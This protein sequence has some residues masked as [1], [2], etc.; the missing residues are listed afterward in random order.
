MTSSPAR[1]ID[2]GTDNT[3]TPDE[4]ATEADTG[5]IKE[6]AIN[7]ANTPKTVADGI[8]N[9]RFVKMLVYPSGD[10]IAAAAMLRSALTTLDTPYHITTVRTPVEA[11]RATSGTEKT[12]TVL[13]I[14]VDLP[15]IDRR[16]P[17]HEDVN[18]DERIDDESGTESETGPPESAS[19]DENEHIDDEDPAPVRDLDD[20]NELAEED[21]TEEGDDGDESTPCTAK[22]G[23]ENGARNEEDDGAE[24]DDERHE[25]AVSGQDEAAIQVGTLPTDRTPR[26]SE[27]EREH[28]ARATKESE[29]SESERYRTASEADSWRETHPAKRGVKMATEAVERSAVGNEPVP[30]EGDGHNEAEIWP[31]NG[32]SWWAALYD[33]Q[34]ELRHRSDKIPPEGTEGTIIASEANSGDERTTSVQE[35]SAIAGYEAGE[36]ETT[37][38]DEGEVGR[39]E[40]NEAKEVNEDDEIGTAQFITDGGAETAPS[41]AAGCLLSVGTQLDE[42]DRNENTEG[43]SLGNV[44]TGVSASTHIASTIASM[45]ERHDE[46]SECEPVLFLA[47][48]MIYSS[49]RNGQFDLGKRRTWPTQYGASTNCERAQAETIISQDGLGT[50]LQSTPSAVQHT[51]FVHADFSGDMNGLAEFMRSCP[52]IDALPDDDEEDEWRQFSEMIRRKSG[53]SSLLDLLIGCHY[54]PEDRYTLPTV[55]GYADV[56]HTLACSGHTAQ[57]LEFASRIGCKTDEDN[58]K[59]VIDRWQNCS[60]EIHDHVRDAEMVTQLDGEGGGAVYEL[61]NTDGDDSC[62]SVPLGQIAVLIDQYRNDEGPTIIMGEENAAAADLSTHEEVRNGEGVRQILAETVTCEA[63]TIGCDGGIAYCNTTK[64]AS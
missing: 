13:S 37:D 25:D 42:R 21:E 46:L 1:P 49:G 14:G 18:G 22:N 59:M 61:E 11:A 19:E 15:Q 54:L 20:D 55:E 60:D 33:V 39:T 28:E 43:N 29:E 48:M 57:A 30:S 51:S 3:T 8:L 7:P 40:D 38:E 36:E 50:P 63:E 12:T 27:A 17:I 16:E 41:V 31:F 4:E 56:L 35:A 44:S 26:R 62:K 9:A 45:T 47:G 5:P 23:G 10:C 32:V 24:E 34:T 2:A 58:D 64:E 6:R 53:D 52:V